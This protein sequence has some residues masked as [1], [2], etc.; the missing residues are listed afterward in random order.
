MIFISIDVLPP[1]LDLREKILREMSKK[2]LE[3]HFIFEN[4][5]LKSKILQLKSVNLPLTSVNLQLMS[6]NLQIA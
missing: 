6:I 5:K 1:K 2:N 4:K 3:V